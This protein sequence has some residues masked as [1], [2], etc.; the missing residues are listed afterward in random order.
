MSDYAFEDALN[1]LEEISPS[2]WQTFNH[3]ERADKIEKIT[4]NL[5]KQY[6]PRGK[7]VAIGYDIDDCQMIVWNAYERALET[8]AVKLGLL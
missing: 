8:G 2:D 5:Y 6:G 4:Q 7:L 3:D 1:Q